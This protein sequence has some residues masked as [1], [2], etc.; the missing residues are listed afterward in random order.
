MVDHKTSV[1]EIPTPNILDQIAMFHRKDYQKAAEVVKQDSSESGDVFSKLMEESFVKL[2][3]NDN[4]RF[5]EK[6]FR[7][8]CKKEQSI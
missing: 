1:G 7:M 2:F 5:D 3:K 8:A 6:R 4:S